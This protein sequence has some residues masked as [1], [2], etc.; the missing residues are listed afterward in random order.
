LY[1]PGASVTD[2]FN[3]QLFV[4]LSPIHAAMN[5]DLYGSGRRYG[6]LAAVGIDLQVRSLVTPPA[7]MCFVM[8]LTLLDLH[9]TGRA[10]CS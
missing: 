8:P 10:K 9:R 3:K 5:L 4:R 7:A 1:R 6:P 2:Y